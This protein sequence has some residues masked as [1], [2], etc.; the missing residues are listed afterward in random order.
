[1]Y[2]VYGTT[3]CGYC[4][5]ATRLLERLDKDYE[6]TNVTTVTAEDRQTLQD[7][8]G[9]EFRTVPQIF[10]IVGNELVYIGGYTDLRNK[11]KD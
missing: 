11:L 1:M 6:Y 5:E 4:I 9:I 2:K 10:E 8:A 3:G 7:V